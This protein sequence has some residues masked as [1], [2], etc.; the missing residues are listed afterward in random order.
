MGD[1]GSVFLGFL[2]ASLVLWLSKSINEFVFLASFIFP[3]YID[4]ISTLIIRI[5]DRDKLTKAHRRHIYQILANQAGFSHTKITIIYGA[6]QIL[7]ISLIWGV[8]EMSI[9]Y[10]ISMLAVLSTIYFIIGLHIRLR[11]ERLVNVT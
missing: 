3:F 4:E 5:K 10:L 1:V 8:K 2:F 9:A 11:W 6:I 7:V